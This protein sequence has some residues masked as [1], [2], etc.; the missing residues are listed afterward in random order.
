MNSIP[1]M[2]LTAMIQSRLTA[3]QRP[4]QSEAADVLAVEVVDAGEGEVL[5]AMRLRLPLNEPT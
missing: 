2:A 5:P 3:D 1:T 4:V